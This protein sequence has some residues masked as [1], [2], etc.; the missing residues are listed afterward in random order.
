MHNWKSETMSALKNSKCQ[1]NQTN[2]VAEYLKEIL[3]KM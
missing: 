2:V 3:N 1:S